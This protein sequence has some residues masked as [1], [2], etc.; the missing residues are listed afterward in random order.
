MIK[1]A[2]IAATA[3]LMLSGAARSADSLI[4]PKTVPGTF[5][6]NV[7]VVSEYFFRGISQTD[8]AP[9]LQGG[10]DYSVELAKPVSLYLGVWGSNVDFNEGA[11]VDGATMELD[12]YGGLNG[13]IGNSGVSWDVGF[14][15]YTYPGAA[16]SLNYD[17]WEVQAKLGYDFKVASV[18]A[19]V[20]YSPENFGDSGKAT[21]YKLAFSVPLGKVDLGAYVAKQYIDKEAVFGSPDYLEWNLSATINLAGFDLS[22]AYTD[23]DISG[24]PDGKDGMVYFSVGRSF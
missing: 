22:V 11:G 2:I 3:V 16:S 24:S 5:S 19:S 17:F 14:I 15:Y 4:D 13:S 12:I 18:E 23:T 7:S 20:N 21:Y 6:A 1:R 8:D 10:M 9:A